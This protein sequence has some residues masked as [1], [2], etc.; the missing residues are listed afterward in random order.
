MSL[1]RRHLLLSAPLL[2][3]AQEDKPVEFLCPMDADVRQKGPG[4]CPRC[5]MKLLPGLPDPVEYPVQL[6]TTPRNP[7]PG[8]PVRLRF[9]VLHPRTRKPVT[10]L[11]L[12]HE[13]V[14]HLFLISEDLQHFAHEHPEAVTPGV[15]EI[16]WTFPTGG[17]WR[18][19]CDFFPGSG[20]PQLVAKT[21][22][23]P[24][25]TLLP[26]TLTPTAPTAKSENCT[27]TLR[28]E[29]PQPIAGQKTLLY[30]RISPRENF[31]LFLGAAGHMLIASADLIDMIHTHPFLIDGG[32][33]TPPSEYKQVQ[34][35][36]IFPRPGW[37]R[38]WAQFKRDG[39]VSTIPFNFEVIGL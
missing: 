20:T 34:F 1:S 19:L 39:V 38:V 15:F 36:V 3:Q 33:P 27:V 2:L 12:I 23:L 25:G 29:P 5:G 8:Q 18:A 10:D 4:K 28:C 21:L 14:F 7:K 11:E 32:L 22:I 6:T 9:T 37:Y 35:N 16:T 24:G 17:L 31:E 26:A 13:R 30:Y